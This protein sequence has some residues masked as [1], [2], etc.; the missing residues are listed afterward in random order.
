[1]FLFLKTQLLNPFRYV[2]FLLLVLAQFFSAFLFFPRLEGN[3]TIVDSYHS[4]P[5]N[6]FVL[7]NISLN[8]AEEYYYFG[9]QVSVYTQ[10]ES[11]TSYSGRLLTSNSFMQ[12]DGSSFSFTSLVEGNP[13]LGVNE[14]GITRKFAADHDLGLESVIH[15]SYGRERKIYSP[16]SVKA[17]YEDVYGIYRLENNDAYGYFVLGYNEDVLM[18]TQGVRYSS[19]FVDYQ[20]EGFGPE[21]YF[22]SHYIDQI[23]SMNREIYL[24]I[25][26]VQILCPILLFLI[27]DSMKL[28]RWNRRL[29][30][31]GFK[32]KDFMKQSLVSSFLLL[33]FSLIPGL[34][35]VFLNTSHAVLVGVYLLFTALCFL[36]GNVVEDVLILR[37]GS[38]ER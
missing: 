37:E 10:K 14:I 16:V 18:N 9:S 34:I 38:Y 12:K 17:I 28:L 36:L 5:F 23:A 15:V 19:F 22:K 29:R 33:S 26:L 11:E 30:L 13:N 6:Q 32:N 4:I 24:Q 25:S 1:M 27:F 21:V 31:F 20:I 3:W 2:L 7:S 35:F 8:T